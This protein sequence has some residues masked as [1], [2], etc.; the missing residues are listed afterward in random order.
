MNYVNGKII[1]LKQGNTQLVAEKIAEYTDV[2]LFEI[3]TEK[4]ILTNIMNARQ[5]RKENCG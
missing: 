4:I 2:K 3:R 5:K 1:E